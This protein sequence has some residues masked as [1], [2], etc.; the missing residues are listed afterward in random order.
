MLDVGISDHR[1][2]VIALTSQLIKGQRKNKVLS[3]L[4]LH[5][6][7]KMEKGRAGSESQK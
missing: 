2:F 5:L 4:Q 3:G 6:N 7:G 1:S